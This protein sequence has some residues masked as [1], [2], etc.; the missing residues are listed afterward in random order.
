MGYIAQLPFGDEDLRKVQ[1]KNGEI[2]SYNDSYKL[3]PL[4]GWQQ[5]MGRLWMDTSLAYM[6]CF[7]DLDDHDSHGKDY[8][9]WNLMFS[10]RFDKLC[11][12]IQGDYINTRESKYYGV[13]QDDDGYNIAAAFGIACFIKPTVELSLKYVADVD[14]K[15]EAQGS[16]I[17]FRM[18]CF[19]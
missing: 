8:L 14:G 18:L 15:N 1:M 11:V 3:M 12:H 13:N 16:G 9:E 10:Y 5:R 19:F 7:D 4:L 2:D 17:N 6:H